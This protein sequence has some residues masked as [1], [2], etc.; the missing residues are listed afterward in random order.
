MRDWT[1]GEEQE[2]SLG[3]YAKLLMIHEGWAL[4]SFETRNGTYLS[5][6][7]PA[8]GNQ[9]PTPLGVQQAFFGPTPFASIIVSGPKPWV[10]VT[11]KH[12]HGSAQFREV[13]ARFLSDLKLGEIH[14][15]QLD[16]KRIEFVVSSRPGERAFSKTVNE[17]GIIDMTGASE[18]LALSRQL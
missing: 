9:H 5:I 4:W 12:I 2:V 14:P 10:S 18:V 16:G 3:N 17:V 11:G 8:E 7:K 13:G 15:D 6:K 1:I